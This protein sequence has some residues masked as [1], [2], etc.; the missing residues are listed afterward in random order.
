MSADLPQVAP[1]FLGTSLTLC[2]VIEALNFSLTWTVGACRRSQ[3]HGKTQKMK[4]PNPWNPSQHASY[5]QSKVQRLG[6]DTSRIHDNYSS[7]TKEN[8]FLYFLPNHDP[9]SW[10][11]PEKSEASFRNSL[12]FTYDFWGV[13]DPPQ[14]IHRINIHTLGTT[15]L[16]KS[17]GNDFCLTSK[18]NNR[19]LVQMIFLSF[20]GAHGCR[21]QPLIFQGV[22][23]FS[24]KC[25]YFN[26]YA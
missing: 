13:T 18:V 11:S 14:Q 10:Y 26:K 23:I 1:A 2:W 21:F 16:P 5:T 20:H 19:G 15:R 24:K 7:T 12:G 25:V 9:K 17:P 22:H 3:K 8:M 4:P 6:G